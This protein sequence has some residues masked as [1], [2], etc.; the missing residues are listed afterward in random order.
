[1]AGDRIL[2][3]TKTDTLEDCGAGE[4][5]GPMLFIESKNLSAGNL[6]AEIECNDSASGCSHN[7]IE[8]LPHALKTESCA[9]SRRKMRHL[10]MQAGEASLNRLLCADP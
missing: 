3:E 1:M 4:D 8:I 10:D 7:Q 9:G 5:C 2:N 6:K